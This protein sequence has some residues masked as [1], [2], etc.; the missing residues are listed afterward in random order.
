MSAK[1][2]TPTPLSL[3]PRVPHATLLIVLSAMILLDGLDKR[4]GLQPPKLVAE[5]STSLHPVTRVQTPTPSLPDYE[6]SQAQLTPTTQSY[7]E[8]KEKRTRRR[9]C[10]RWTIYALAAYFVSTVVI[11]IP[12]IVVVRLH[13]RSHSLITADQRCVVPQK[14]KRKTSLK[15]NP[16]Q[17]WED[18]APL[19][20]RSITLGSAPLR[21]SAAKACNSWNVKDRPDGSMFLSEYVI[22]LPRPSACN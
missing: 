20:P 8:I 6:A 17:S 18:N 9:R 12:I 14:L 16:Y 21:I 22:V 13:S 7:T 1:V 19:P 3:L 15:T 10:R 11:G 4:D 2:L 5:A